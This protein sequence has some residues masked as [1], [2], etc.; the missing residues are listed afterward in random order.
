MNVNPGRASSE[1]SRPF[2]FPFRSRPTRTRALI[3]PR[4]VILGPSF[5]TL[6]ASGRGARVRPPDIVS[7]DT[8]RASI[9]RVSFPLRS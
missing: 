8:S 1:M 4:V 5:L 2:H 9:L 7:N 3:F 6:T